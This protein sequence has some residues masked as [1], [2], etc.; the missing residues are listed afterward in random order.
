MLKETKPITQAD[1]YKLRDKALAD[2]MKKPE[3][4]P[5]PKPIIKPKTA[6]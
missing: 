6:T 5:K 4:E 2:S 1:I 3:P